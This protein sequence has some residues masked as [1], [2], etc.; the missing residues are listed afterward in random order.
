MLEGEIIK[1]YLR[2]KNNTRIIDVNHVSGDWYLEKHNLAPLTWDTNSL[3]HN[4]WIGIEKGTY[5]EH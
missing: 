4:G 2:G 3:N 5:D 1:S